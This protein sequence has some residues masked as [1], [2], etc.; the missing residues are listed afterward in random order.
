MSGSADR[1]KNV[2]PSLNFLK[3]VNAD[4][5]DTFKKKTIW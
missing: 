5:V 2:R 4:D 1:E 3:F